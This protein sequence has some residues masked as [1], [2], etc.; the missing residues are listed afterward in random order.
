MLRSSVFSIPAISR[1]RLLALAFTLGSLQAAAQGNGSNYMLILASGFLCDPGD[2]STC[3]AVAK[4]AEGDRYELTGAGTFDVHDKSVKAA[5]T[6]AHK[7]SDGS[8]LETGVWLASELH[9]FRSYGAATDALPPAGRAP[10]PRPMG[11]RRAPRSLRAVPTG[12]LAIFHIR[13]LPVTGPSKTAVLQV[14]AALGSVP[15]EGPTEGI[16]LV[17]ERNNREF[18]EEASGSVMFLLVPREVNTPARQEAQPN[19]N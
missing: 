17:L 3:P 12:G 18:S 5:G 1:T 16:R 4:A 7:S 10:G 9:S 19:P 6:F 11:P 8:T 2:S 13:L 14:N 15:P